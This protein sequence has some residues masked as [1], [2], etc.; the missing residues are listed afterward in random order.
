MTDQNK[1]NDETFSCSIN[2]SS[3]DYPARGVELSY[4]F[5]H[6]MTDRILEGKDVPPSYAAAHEIASIIQMMQ[7]QQPSFNYTD[8][9][10]AAMP[11]DKQDEAIREA[12]A[13]A[14]HTMRVMRLPKN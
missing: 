9:E 4:S 6:D 2:F 1:T 5:S 11:E 3:K 14:I 13:T 7:S 10:L 12:A 8:E